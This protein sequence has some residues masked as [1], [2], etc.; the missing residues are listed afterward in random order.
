MDLPEE[1]KRAPSAPVWNQSFPSLRWICLKRLSE[2]HLPL[3]EIGSFYGPVCVR[4]YYSRSSDVVWVVVVG[5]W[6]E[7]NS[8][9]KFIALL[10]SATMHCSMRVCLRVNWWCQACRHYLFFCASC[11]GSHPHQLDVQIPVICLRTH[12]VV[13]RLA[14]RSIEFTFNSNF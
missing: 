10:P 13:C 6:K 2:L 14:D 12:D 11:L 5:W 3:F 8:L 7:V 1:A 9:T 4:I